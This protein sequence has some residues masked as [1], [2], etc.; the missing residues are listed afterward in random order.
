MPGRRPWL[1]AGAAAVVLAAGSTVGMAAAAGTFDAGAPTPS[2]SG[3]GCTAPTLPGE[4][5]DVTLSD[6]GGRMTGR[7]MMDGPMMGGSMMDGSTAG[8]W[9]A[10]MMSVALSTSGVRADVVSFRVANVGVMTHELVVLPLPAGQQAGRRRVD[11]DGTVDESASL[12]EASRSC[13]A[14]EGAGI[15]AGSVGWLTVTLRPGRYELVCNLPGHYTAGM[16]AEL[17]VSSG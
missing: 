1:L 4:L 8:R 13:G 15:R 9:R 11:A 3:V 17:D 14:G 5:V 2:S 12:G 16:F 6:M 7:S 10:G